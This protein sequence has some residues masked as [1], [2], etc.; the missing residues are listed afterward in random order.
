MEEAR[1]LFEALGA[2]GVMMWHVYRIEG[3]YT[4]HS[5]QQRDD[6]LYLR[7]QNER[8]THGAIV[9]SDDETTALDVAA[10]IEGGSNNE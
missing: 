10:V 3:I 6:Y 1:T 5:Q 8:L 4:T 2:V 7:E 9:A